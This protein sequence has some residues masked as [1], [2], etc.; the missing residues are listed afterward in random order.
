[1]N[2]F[3][4]SLLAISCAAILTGCS[5]SDDTPAT[6]TTMV[7]PGTQNS[8]NT[9]TNN[10]SNSNSSQNSSTEQTKQPET[11]QPETKQPE[12]K[13]PETSGKDGDTAFGGDSKVM[14]K[15]IDGGVI[16]AK[17]RDTGDLEYGAIESPVSRTK[18]TVVLDG[19]SINT[20]VVKENAFTTHEKSENGGKQGAAQL[21]VHSGNLLPDVRYGS[22][23][24]LTD[25]HFQNN[26]KQALF[27]Q[28]SPSSRDTVAA[29]KGE[30]TYEGYGL[31]FTDGKPFRVDYDALGYTDITK[32]DGKFANAYSGARATKVTA[33]VNFDEKT[34][35]VN[36]NRFSDKTRNDNDEEDRLGG[37]DGVLKANARDMENL[38]FNG[39]LTGNTFADDA[40]NL[41]GGFYGA[42]A[43][44]LAGMYKAKG[45]L[46]GQE[47][48]TRGVFGAK[49]QDGGNAVAPAEQPKPDTPTA[50]P[51]TPAATAEVKTGETG[52]KYL[53]ADAADLSK[54]VI[55]GTTI[56]LA[57]ASEALFGSK[58]LVTDKQSIIASNNLTNVVIGA[59]KLADDA[60][61]LFVQGTMSASLPSGTAKYSG[62]VLNFRARNLDEKA[63]WID[64]GNSYRSN[65]SFTA[66]V[67]FD[68]K[69]ITGNINSGD[70]WYMGSQG[71]TA[72]ITG[73]NFNG[74]WTSGVQGDVSG[75]FYGDNA[76]EMAGRYSYNKTPGNNG[77]NSD[78]AFGVFGGK[79]Q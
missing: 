52:E 56:A 57:P 27:V 42:T 2:H 13:Q 3:K 73:S 24:D 71:F 9:G 49:R 62:D 20:K 8:G 37:K 31:H 30:A 4:M 7:Q 76:T 28:G 29:Q 50:K 48:E 1:M 45:E 11:K 61:S 79:K 33:K 51:D 5:S 78:N 74:K 53:I 16:T 77:S 47:V 34:I 67:N 72:D 35:G 46:R 64:T 12:T 63:N 60:Y 25:A 14:T 22:V 65:G 59:A 40:G 32:S 54:V 10:N 69:T 44:Q 55:N 39:K 15:T 36:V 19:V 43:D 6:P 75:G 17:K 18:D 23:A 41:Q 66:D 21:S 58:G 26:V 38:S 70:R 68:A